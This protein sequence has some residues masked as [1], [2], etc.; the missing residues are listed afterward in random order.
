MSGLSRL[1]GEAVHSDIAVKDQSGLDSFLNGEA[2]S[3]SSNPIR[4]LDVFELICFLVEGYI[5]SD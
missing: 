1:L 4:G 2:I 5:Y 3:F